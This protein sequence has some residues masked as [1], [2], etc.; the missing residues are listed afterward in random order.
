M[1]CAALAHGRQVDRVS[2]QPI[3]QVFAELVRG[4][5]CPPGCGSSRRS[6]RTSVEITCSPPTRWNCCSCSTRSNLLCSSG[7]MSPI[8]SRNNVPPLHCSNLPMRRLSAPVKDPLLVPEQLAFEQRLGN[9]RTVHRQKRP[10][11]PLAELVQ[12]RAT[13]SL[14]VPLSPRINTV[15]FCDATRPIALY[16]SCIAGERPMMTSPSVPSRLRRVAGPS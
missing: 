9:R 13:S 5:P 4:R 14:P 15:T 11:R 16:T 10:L 7:G 1:S 12:R 6:T 3:E 2:V 8:S